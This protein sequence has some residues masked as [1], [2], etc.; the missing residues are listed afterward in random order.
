MAR[1]KEMECGAKCLIMG[2]VAAALAAGGLWMVVAG[3]LK[4]W[5]GMMPWTT[6]WL[7]Y[8]GG[9]ILVCIAKHCRK[10]SC[11]MCRV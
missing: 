9:F 11:M 1:M 7:W 6:V 10:Q 8:F 2:L 4:Q 5:S 3:V